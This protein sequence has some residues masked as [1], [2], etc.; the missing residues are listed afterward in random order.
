MST[1]INPSK[2]LV[3][4]DAAEKSQKQLVTSGK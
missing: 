3:V 2:T 4:T 1:E